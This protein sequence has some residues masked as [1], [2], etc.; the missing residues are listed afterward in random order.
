VRK[1]TVRITIALKDDL[2]M[3]S[4]FHRSTKKLLQRTYAQHYVVV[5][6]MMVGD[7]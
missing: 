7:L 2:M 3:R 5:V 6:Q 4:K 1:K